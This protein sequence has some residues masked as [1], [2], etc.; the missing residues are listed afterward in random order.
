MSSTK[1]M[2]S[3]LDPFSGYTLS[4]SVTDTPNLEENYINQEQKNFN[5]LLDSNSINP[6]DWTFNIDSQN[7]NYNLTE[8]QTSNISYYLVPYNGKNNFFIFLTLFF[9]LFCSVD[10]HFYLLIYFFFFEFEHYIII[11]LK[12]HTHYVL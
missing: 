11:Y 2:S 1:E 3:Y 10:F 12:L 7:F 4:N 9:K 5:N 8:A 6:K